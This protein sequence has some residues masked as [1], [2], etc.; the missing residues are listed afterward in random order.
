MPYKPGDFSFVKDDFQRQCLTFDY[1]VVEKNDLWNYFQLWDNEHSFQ[2]QSPTS[3]LLINLDKY[4]WYDG[5]MGWSFGMS[6]RELAYIA[7]NGWQSLVD[8]YLAKNK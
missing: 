6:M 3:K 5:H 8:I 2:Y 1:Q 4:E 7:K